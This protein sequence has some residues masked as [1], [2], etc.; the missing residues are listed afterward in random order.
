MG[1]LDEVRAN[2]YKHN[3]QSKIAEIKSKL[4]PEDYEEFVVAISDVTISQAALIRALQKRGIKIGTGTISN[5][6]RDLLA[7]GLDLA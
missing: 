6:R 7:G 2:D 5:M 3:R 1:L 4:T